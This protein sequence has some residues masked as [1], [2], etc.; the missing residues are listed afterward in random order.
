[1]VVLVPSGSG[2]RSSPFVVT[3]V[4]SAKIYQQIA[5]PFCL[6]LV[7]STHRRIRRMAIAQSGLNQWTTGQFHKQ[8]PPTEHSSQSSPVEPTKEA[9]SPWSSKSISFAPS[10]PSSFNLPVYASPTS[11]FPPSAV[12]TPNTYE[13]MHQPFFGFHS[14]GSFSSKS[15]SI[16]DQSST[17]GASPMP[18]LYKDGGK[19]AS[20]YGRHSIHVL[21][22]ISTS[23]VFP[24]RAGGGDAKGRAHLEGLDK[25]YCESRAP[26]CHF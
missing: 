2:G 19:R 1:M 23:A 9:L 11:S 16:L 10:T 8:S 25:R 15:P 4:Y 21:R 14:P 6:S 26:D 20:S 18:H 12:Q 3:I 13:H 5:V 22:R 7:L 17:N 24:S